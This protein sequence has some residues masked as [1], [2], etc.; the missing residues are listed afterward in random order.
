MSETSSPPQKTNYKELEL[1][2]FW[3]KTSK[4]NKKYCTGNLKFKGEEVAVVM[5][6]EEN[7]KSPNAPDY[8]VY[9]SVPR[10]GATKPTEAAAKSE[11]KAVATPPASEEVPF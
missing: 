9:L 3:V 5:F 2:A 10:D 6:K 1:G 8:R 4:T 7:K 11:S